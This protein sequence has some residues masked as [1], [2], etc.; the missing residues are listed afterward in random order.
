MVGAILI[1]L[2]LPIVSNSVV[3]RVSWNPLYRGLFWLFVGNLLILGNI[4]ALPVEY[5]WE[6]LGKIGTVLYFGIILIIIPILGFLD[7]LIALS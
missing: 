3:T 1:L 4:G 7:V 5:P 6:T 2:V